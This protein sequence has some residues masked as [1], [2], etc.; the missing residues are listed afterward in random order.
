VLQDAES[1]RHVGPSVCHI[2]NACGP[3]AICRS[4]VDR[5]AHKYR[6]DAMLTSVTQAAAACDVSE[7]SISIKAKPTVFDLTAK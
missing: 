2:Q 1:S 3:L 7:D 5:V 6:R 4:L